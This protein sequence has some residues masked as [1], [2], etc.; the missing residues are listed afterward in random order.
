MPQEKT[1][2]SSHTRPYPQDLSPP[3]LVPHRVRRQIPLTPE[4][5]PLGVSGYQGPDMPR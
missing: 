1:D 4:T 2:A 3:L 5:D